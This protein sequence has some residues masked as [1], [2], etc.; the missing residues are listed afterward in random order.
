MAKQV[1]LEELRRQEEVICMPVESTRPFALLLL[2]LQ[3]YIDLEQ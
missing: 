3:H 2:M 1:P